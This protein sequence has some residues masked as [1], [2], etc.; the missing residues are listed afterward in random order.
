MTGSDPFN[1]KRDNINHFCQL[2]LDIPLY[3]AKDSL[4][5]VYEERLFGRYDVHN[6][7]G[8]RNQ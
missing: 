6:P 1:S 5:P 8:C 2:F 7:A 3:T 4:G